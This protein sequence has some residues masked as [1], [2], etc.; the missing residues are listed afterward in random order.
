MHTY[1]YIEDKNSDMVVMNEPEACIGPLLEEEAWEDDRLVN[2]RITLSGDTEVHPKHHRKW[3][4]YLCGLQK[5]IPELRNVLHFNEDRGCLQGIF[6]SDAHS[7]Q[8]I[9]FLWS[10]IR[11]GWEN[12]FPRDNILDMY[13]RGVRP[14]YALF[15]GHWY[16]NNVFNKGDFKIADFD[17]EESMEEDAWNSGHSLIS[18]STVTNSYKD[19]MR[20]PQSVEG[21]VSHWNNRLAEPKNPIAEEQGPTM[22]FVQDTFHPNG[23]WVDREHF[24]KNDYPRVWPKKLE[25]SEW[26]A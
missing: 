23:I 2:T 11:Y 18:R 20:D 22:G 9:A 24:K 1:I 21:L 26:Q 16:W 12:Y 14:D 19:F 7:V 5:Y 6:D 17:Q 25:L 8:Y 10:I 13:S 15:L 4:N 3:Y